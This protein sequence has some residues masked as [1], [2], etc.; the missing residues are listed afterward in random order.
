MKTVFPR[1][2]FFVLVLFAFITLGSTSTFAK[3]PRVDRASR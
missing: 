3:K 1:Y 2:V